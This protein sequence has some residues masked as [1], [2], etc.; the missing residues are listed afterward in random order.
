MRRLLVLSLLGVSILAGGNLCAQARGGGF[1]GGGVQGGGVHGGGRP[2]IRGGEGFSNRGGFSHH[3][4]PSIFLG[5]PYYPFGYD[6][7]YDEPY[8]GPAVE[9][10]PPPMF[11]SRPAPAAVPVAVKI[12]EV[13]AAEKN[14]APRTPSPAL[15]VFAN[16]NRL[17][18]QRYMLTKDFLYLTTGPQTR[19]PLGALDLQATIAANRERGIDLQIPFDS[20][21]ISLGF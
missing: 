11:I 20:N 3:T 15:F 16:G 2:G 7:P 6:E 1:H 12:I 4:G 18:A 5:Y 8:P 9:S 14:G 19:F 17:E 13:P 10:L 21:Q